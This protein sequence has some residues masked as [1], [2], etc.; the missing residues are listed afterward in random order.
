MSEATTA[1][2]ERSGGF[3]GVKK[4]RLT[5]QD[6]KSRDQDVIWGEKAGEEFKKGIR[7]R[8][9]EIGRNKHAI[10]VAPL[11]RVKAPDI[12]FFVFPVR[13]KI[14]FPHRIE[15]SVSAGKCEKKSHKERKEITGPFFHSLCD[16]IWKDLALIVKNSQALCQ[17]E[18][19]PK[20]IVDR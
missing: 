18:K 4:V 20:N 17:A 9:K 15:K 1:I 14:G 12:L 10:Q 13:K 5:T 19:C 8:G 16:Q 11:F 6:R 3:Q 2:S 7:K